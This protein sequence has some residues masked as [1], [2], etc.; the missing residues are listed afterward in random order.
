MEGRSG[1]L[2]VVRNKP[3]AG[4]DVKGLMSRSKPAPAGTG[5]GIGL[6]RIMSQDSAEAVARQ[7]NEP[8]A[9]RDSIGLFIFIVIPCC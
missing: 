6:G 2:E 8:A 9:I 5:L 4:V 1:P 7:A 3:G